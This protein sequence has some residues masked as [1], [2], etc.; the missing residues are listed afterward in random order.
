MII[1]TI[2][3]HKFLHWNTKIGVYMSWS[4]QFQ[5]LKWYLLEQIS[6]IH[7]FVCN[8]FLTFWIYF[9]TTQVNSTESRTPT[10]EVHRGKQE[11]LVDAIP[12]EKAPD[13]GVCVWHFL[14]LKKNDHCFE[15]GQ[16]L[17]WRSSLQHS[18]LFSYVAIAF[19][20]Y[21]SMYVTLYVAPFLGST[22]LLLLWL[23]TSFPLPPSCPV[24]YIV[25]MF[26]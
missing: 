22:F 19:Y 16:K 23:K 7:S 8:F 17:D 20:L 4:K 10:H 14:S 26:N 2:C 3:F 6:P 1:K 11:V 15:P 9:R 13:G 21:I 12:T 24:K 18:S 5:R 25:P